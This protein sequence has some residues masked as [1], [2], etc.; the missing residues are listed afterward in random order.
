MAN[1]NNGLYEF[2][3]FRLDTAQRLL[4][5]DDCPVALQPKA[6]DTLLMLVRNSEKVVLKD[7]LLNA[8]WADTFVQ[9]SNLTQNIFVLR[10]ALGDND[11]GRRYIITVP[12]RGY[13]F[14]EKVRTITE[15]EVAAPQD[16]AAAQ[17]V[18]PAADTRNKAGKT[19]H[20][21]RAW[22]ASSL[23]AVL[24]VVLA[25]LAYLHF[26]RRPKLTDKDTIVLADFANTTGDPVF[27]GTM[28]QGLSIQL[29]QSPFLNLLSDQRIEQTLSLMARPKDTRL[30]A[31]VAREVCQRTASAAVLSGFIAQVGTRYLLTLYAVNCS[32][33]D[34][35]A[36]AQA[37]ASDKNHV[38]DALG[39]MTADIRAELGESL[40]S[41][42]KL[43]T[44]LDN[45][46]TPS[47][48]ALQAYSLGHQA[49]LLGHGS[50]ATSFYER[51]IGLDPNF[52]MAY[53]GLGIIYFNTDETSHAAENIQK[54]YQLREGVSEREKLGIALVYDAVVTRNFEASRA[55]DLVFTRTYPRDW[56]AFSNLAT[57]DAYLG[58]Y[59]EALAASQQALTLN[60]AAAQNYSNLMID[61]MYTNRLPQAAAIAGE[62]K[63]RNL[64][65]PFLHSNRYLV[66]F[67]A[68]DPAGMEREA[69]E[70]MSKPGSED[71]VLSYESDTAAY[72]G[73]FELARQLTRRAADSA[74]R[75][76]KKETTAEYQAEAAVREA[77]IGNLTL[78]QQEAKG[79]LKLS[80]GRDVVAMAAVSLGL[81]RDFAEAT[82]L[83]DDLATRFPEDTV[84]RYNLAPSIR[85][86]AALRRGEAERAIEE[87]A[88]TLPYETGQTSQDVA[89]A[90]YPIYLRGEAYLAAKQ[91]R[92]AAAEFQKIHDH[93][94]LV[95]NE[96]IGALAHLGL[97]RAYVM[98]H[99][100]S[101][102][103]TPYV[104]FLALWKAAD[105][106][107]P[108]LIEARTEFAKLP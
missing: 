5:R 1:E 75:A 48:E 21:R 87:L 70:A 94:G 49:E 76:G 64:D 33:G 27:D 69:A 9:E 15:A 107:L 96:L 44:P 18:S 82:R 29:E 80:N 6:F 14:A 88:A 95:E 12:G 7:E 47:L 40:A 23:A 35:L 72:G 11:G 81:A 98:A 3:P 36:S 50:E 39:R 74:L 43:D 30:T 16:A 37:Q 78:A 73:Q 77:L 45:V 89:F 8:V 60:P 65:S 68:H 84:V 22:L 24:A 13:R 52:A 58:H 10:K 42:Q 55:S 97:G 31:E 91:G 100:T 106:D 2:G 103:K 51:A 90:L 101:K 54:A 104:D 20:S 56:R 41:V 79:A 57:I 83:S 59:D 63:A 93:P 4:L 19:G 34:Q 38:L 67:V 32:N 108:I 26:H 92:A 62:A 25:V 66:D 61:Y 17:P 105:P 86:A 71:L 85:A 102:A 53:V 28:R 46:T 99:E